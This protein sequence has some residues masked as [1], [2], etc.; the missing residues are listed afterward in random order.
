MWKRALS[1]SEA[2]AFTTQSETG[3]PDLLRSTSRR[4]LLGSTTGGGGG[5]GFQPAWARGSNVIL[6]AGS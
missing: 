6:G 3:Y 1:D 5:G 4:I 2:L